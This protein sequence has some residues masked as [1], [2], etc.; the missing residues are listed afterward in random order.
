M[1]VAA[2]L[3]AL[4]TPCL[5][6]SA[7]FTQ[8]QLSRRAHLP[9]SAASTGPLLCLA[10]Q[11]LPRDG[12]PSTVATYAAVLLSF[13]LLKAWPAPAFNNP[14]FA[15]VVPARQRSLVYAFDRCFEGE[16][17]QGGGVLLTCPHD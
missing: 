4:A 7:R 6:A 10:L 5:A 9:G 12:Q 8:Q 13:A 15:E 1:R 3:A 11:G 14:A 16:R 2:V 17:G